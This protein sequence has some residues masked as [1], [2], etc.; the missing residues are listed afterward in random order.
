MDGQ[1]EVQSR[2]GK[3]STFTFTLP[4]KP[5]QPEDLG[6]KDPESGDSPEA[7]SAL[8]QQ[9]PLCILVAE[10]NAINRKLITILLEK[11][12]YRPDSVINGQE[13]LQALE[14]R[15]YDLIFMDIQMPLLD[16]LETSRKIVETFPSH[17]RPTIIAMTA[18]ALES[19]RKQ[20]LAA[21]MDDF[22]AKP[23]QAGVIQKMI[24]KWG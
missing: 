24:A 15:R 3:G 16:G 11:L 20:C 5:A 8:A 21:G 1:I 2:E 12:G 10:D 17:Q 18:N 19:D 4:M 6:F 22:I 13:V 23:L 14:T 7:S 9:F